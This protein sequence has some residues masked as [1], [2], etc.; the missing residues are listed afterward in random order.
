MFTWRMHRQVILFILLFLA[1]IATAN[2]LFIY[3]SLTV[4]FFFVLAM[5]LDRPAGI[6]V[7][8]DGLRMMARDDDLVVFRNS[9][10][11]ERGIGIVAVSDTLPEH[12]KLEEGN[13]FHVY[14]KGPGKL[15]ETF[16]YK[17]RCTR[18]GSYKIEAGRAEAIH[19][20]GLEQTEILEPAQ[21]VELIVRPRPTALHRMRDPR[22]TSQLPMPLGARCRIGMTTTDFLEIRS[23][24]QGDPYHSINWTA[25]ARLPDSPGKVP[26]VN[27]F[28]KEGRKT[29]WVFLDAREW[30]RAGSSVEN[31]FEYAVQAALG[32][33]QFYLSRNCNVGLSFF[34]NYEPVIPDG[35]K[36]QSY[37]I[38]RRLID[39][40]IIG[41][42]GTLGKQ[43]TLTEAVESC[44]G[45]MAGSNPYFIVIT[46]IEP[47]NSA[48]LADGIRSMR[49]FSESGGTAPQVMVLHIQGHDLSVSDEC[50]RA[51][52]ALVDLRNASVVRAIRRSGAFVVPWNPR[53]SNL[54]KVMTLGLKRKLKGA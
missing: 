3:L 8:A 31:A 19:V 50:D 44:R 9:V 5:L 34:N 27:D 12:F 41:Q 37:K 17:V 49:K 35:G 28:E 40:E 45:H 32:V 21:T 42:P 10:T 11:A 33:S 20:S 2:I 39:V 25:T 23:Y 54:L 52:A 16:E 48:D 43:V 22:V 14:A 30:M 1:G 29:V 47:R 7:K 26:L 4:L 15:E 36:K 53:S 24:N 6:T 46:M 13:N 51:S 38:A 18:R